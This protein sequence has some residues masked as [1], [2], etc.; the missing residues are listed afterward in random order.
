MKTILIADDDANLRMLA[1]L[2]LNDPE[3]QIIEAEDGREA[4]ELTRSRHPDL[5]ILDWMMPDMNGIE[6]THALQSDP[7]TSHIPI[8]MLTAKARL[9]DQ[10]RGRAAGV[11]SYLVK[12]FSPL[13]LREQIKHLWTTPSQDPTDAAI[14]QSRAGDTPLPFPPAPDHAQT[15]LFAHDLVLVIDAERQKAA[16]LAET[17][18]ALQ[19]EIEERKRIENTLR[20]TQAELE[21]RVAERTAALSLANGQLTQEIAARRQAEEGL[22]TLSRQVLD[23][24][25]S[26]RRRLARELHDEI[27]QALTA[28]KFNLHAAQRQP[29]TFKTRFEDSLGI[30]DYTLQQVRNLSFDLRPAMLDELGLVAAVNWYMGRQSE[31]GGFTAHLTVDPP[32]PT[33]GPTIATTCFRVVQE[34]V[35]NVI[36]HAHAKD[37]W[38][39]LQQ[40][41]TTVAL[42]L[43]DNGKGFDVPAAQERAA[44][45][46]SM[47]LP[48]MHERIRLAGGQIQITSAPGQGT[49]IHV[50]L[51]PPKEEA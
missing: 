42:T 35:T 44:L 15:M 22:H 20:Q 23:A 49:T 14:T 43:R 24:Q 47:G 29:E 50:D 46:A 6:V 3:Y 8:I 30:V 48:G 17:N 38:I 7:R 10:Q 36:R 2:T 39:D 26:E 1:R 28:I 31:R 12:P 16:A 19:A 45:G 51:P 34:A 37:V 27:G 21:H 13:A 41:A 25:E 5:L 11:Q 33:L 40:T 32:S 18:L 9:E 4:L